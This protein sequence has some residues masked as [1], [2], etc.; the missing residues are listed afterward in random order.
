MRIIAFRLTLAFGWIAVVALAVIATQE[1]GLSKAV[2]IFFDDVASNPWRAQFNVDLGIHL[3]LAAAWIVY[4]SHS[5]PLGIA[6]GALALF[7][8]GGFTLAYL[9]VIS[10]LTRGD[11]RRLLL[12]RHA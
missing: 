8:G 9:L 6:L 10:I 7:C 3:L 12:G 4:R 2:T 11:M 5:L 1:L